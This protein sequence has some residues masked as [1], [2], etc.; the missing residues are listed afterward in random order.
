MIYDAENTFMYQQDVSSV[1]TS[2]VDS[3]VVAYGKGDAQAPL[4][5]TVT[6]SEPLADAATVAVET[7]AKATM[8]SKKVLATFVMPKG[9]QVLKAKLPQ[10]SLGYLRVHAAATSGNLKGK[11]TAALV[12]DA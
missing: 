8:A 10:G 12:M 4:W 1:G 6:V 11:M 9:E 5:L 2:G 3:D 7:A